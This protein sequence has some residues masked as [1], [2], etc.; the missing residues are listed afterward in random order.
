MFNP[1]KSE[2]NFFPQFEL[3]SNLKIIG[4]S[5]P[6]GTEKSDSMHSSTV[7][8]SDA[9]YQGKIAITISHK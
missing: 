5:D 1:T 4:Q 9:S 2:S 6:I 3:N 8:Q 7:V